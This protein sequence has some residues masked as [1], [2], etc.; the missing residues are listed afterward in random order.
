MKREF[1]LSAKGPKEY[2]STAIVNLLT[3]E[4]KITVTPRG[5]LSNS[6]HRLYSKMSDIIS[7]IKH[8][9]I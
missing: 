9:Y 5:G 1:V 6:G 3:R 2:C 8:I 7:S 4:Y